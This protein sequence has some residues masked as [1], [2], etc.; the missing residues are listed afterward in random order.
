MKNV[1]HLIG[2]ATA[3]SLSKAINNK[4]NIEVSTKKTYAVYAP[5]RTS[6]DLHFHTAWSMETK[7]FDKPNIKSD[8]DKLSRN[9]S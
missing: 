2:L 6:C 5:S 7:P 8:T 3:K 1:L 4:W 9:I